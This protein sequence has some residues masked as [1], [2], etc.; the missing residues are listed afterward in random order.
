MPRT[1]RVT[2]AV[3]LDGWLDG[4]PTPE[5]TPGM[6]VHEFKGAT[7]GCIASGIA[8]SFS[9]GGAEP[10]FELPYDAVEDVAGSADNPNQPGDQS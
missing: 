2:R 1:L 6:I 4:T 10:F 7:Y 5:F 3:R 9:P 8:V